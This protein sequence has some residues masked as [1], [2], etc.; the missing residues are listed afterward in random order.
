M[1]HIW[2]GNVLYSLYIYS[3]EC[4]Y[5]CFLNAYRVIAREEQQRRQ[6][7]GF[8]CIFHHVADY[9]DKHVIIQ[10]AGRNKPELRSTTIA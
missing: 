7:P 5:N 9:D 3:T 2:D 6:Q 1:R 10:S 8:C 4:A